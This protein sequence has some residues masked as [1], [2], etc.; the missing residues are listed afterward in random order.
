MRLAQRKM[1]HEDGVRVLRQRL[2]AR[3]G[4]G[5]ARGAPGGARGMRIRTQKYLVRA[6]DALLRR[7][8]DGIRHAVGTKRVVIK[9]KERRDHELRIAGPRR[10]RILRRQH[11]VLA[12]HLDEALVAGLAAQLV[13]IEA[14]E[15]VVARHP[16]ET[17]EPRRE[18]GEDEAEILLRLA[19]VTAEDEP[20]VRRG[21][22]PFDE[23]TILRLPDVEIADRE[24]TQRRDH[25]LSLGTY[26]L[27]M[28]SPLVAALLALIAC[29]PSTTEPPPEAA[30]TER[31]VIATLVT[32][33]RRVSIL[34]GGDLRV[35]VHDR[36]GH[37]LADRI[38]VDELRRADPVLGALVTN[39]VAK[40]D[41]GTYLD[42][43]LDLPA[44]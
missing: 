43:T 39:A 15:L 20:I 12:R 13:R 29:A 27:R 17:R 35:S 1:I 30:K 44:R 22:D 2:E 25:S 14:P 6:F 23:R 21:R 36:D 7:P 26:T 33:D 32:H 10:I 9:K 37:L 40:S 8:R 3:R 4:R 18:R 42:A 28:R 38:T 19:K 24:E 41:D 31:P 34:S 11:P 16:D 5:A